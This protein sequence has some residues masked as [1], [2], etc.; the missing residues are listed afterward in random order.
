MLRAD[1]HDHLSIVATFLSHDHLALSATTIDLLAKVIDVIDVLTF[2]ELSEGLNR[3]GLALPLTLLQTRGDCQALVQPIP[4]LALAWSIRICF[5]G[6]LLL[7]TPWSGC[8]FLRG[9]QHD[10]GCWIVIRQS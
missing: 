4:Q 8:R 5:G 6:A 7:S 1:L 9:G 2:S 3:L 10:D